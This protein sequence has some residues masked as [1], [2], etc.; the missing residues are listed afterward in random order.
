M[1]EFDEYLAR[2]VICE[3]RVKEASTENEKQHWL[4]MADAWRETVK[5]QDMLMR[6]MDFIS[7][8]P[9]ARPSGA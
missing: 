3:Q 2:V 7:K 4:T 1:P 8:V 5:L 9:T 6:Q